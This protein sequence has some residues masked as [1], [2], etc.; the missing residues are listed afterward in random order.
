VFTDTRKLPED[1]ERVTHLSQLAPRYRHV[2]FNQRVQKGWD[3]PEAY[4]CY[5]D[6]A[7]RSFTRIGQIV[8][9]VLRQ[10]AARR[11]GHEELNTA[12]LILQTPAESYERVVTRAARRAAPLC[13]ARRAELHAGAAQDPQGAAA[14]DRDQA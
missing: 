13:A 4:V 7:T 10:P 3:D 5:F 2:I 6:S 9:R 14:A 11:F 8:G 1:A 12:T